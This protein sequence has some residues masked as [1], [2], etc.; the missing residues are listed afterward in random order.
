[1]EPVNKTD[2]EIGNPQND[3]GINDKVRSLNTLVIGVLIVVGL[4]FVG[5]ISTI[6]LEYTK[7]SRE[8]VE[9]AIRQ[10]EKIELLYQQ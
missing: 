3:T 2:Q 5:F 10:S 9:Q 4:A 6:I 1:M 7:G 8:F